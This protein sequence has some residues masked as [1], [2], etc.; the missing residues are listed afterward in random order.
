MRDDVRQALA[1][2]RSSG[3]RERTIDITTA[4]RRSGE[5]RRI[6]TWFY[7]L[8][9]AIYLSGP[10]GQRTRR[11]LL[12]LEAQPRFSFHLKGDVVADL[13]ATAEVITDPDERRR[14]LSAFYQDFRRRNPTAG[15]SVEDWI[16]R[17]P[18]ARVRFDDT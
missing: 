1:I 11:W 9:D 3:P 7:R 18:L 16:S 6:E 13:P 2:D 10:P 4:G 8:D 14:V 5:P 12:N 15:T 17:S